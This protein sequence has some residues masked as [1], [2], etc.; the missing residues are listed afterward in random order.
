MNKTMNELHV[1]S[2]KGKRVDFTAV[3]VSYAEE[4]EE[5]VD[6]V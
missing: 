3:K 6:D 4:V 5:I 2:S 1:G